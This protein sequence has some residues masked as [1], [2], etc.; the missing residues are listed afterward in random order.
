MQKETLTRIILLSSLIGICVG[1]VLLATS[2]KTKHKNLFI[3]IG[4]ILV[5]IPFL[6]L[7]S[8][9]IKVCYDKYHKYKPRRQYLLDLLDHELD[10]H[11]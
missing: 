2:Y 4:S 8:G 9:K 5:S 7:I 10:V 3:I 11:V 1:I 6:W